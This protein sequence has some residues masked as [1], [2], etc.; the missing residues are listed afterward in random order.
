MVGHYKVTGMN[1]VETAKIQS[2]MHVAKLRNAG[3]KNN[4]RH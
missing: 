2:D 1:R 4:A 3:Q